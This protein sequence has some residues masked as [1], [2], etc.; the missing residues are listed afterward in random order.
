[1]TYETE[2]D[3]EERRDE[4]TERRGDGGTDSGLLGGEAV[5]VNRC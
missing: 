5:R 4:E 2:S 1:M 3:I